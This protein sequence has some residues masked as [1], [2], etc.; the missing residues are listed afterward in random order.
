MSQ[1]GV[2]RTIGKL[3]TDERFRSQFFAN[4]QVAAH[5]AGLPLS[6]TELEALAALSVDAVVRF[7]QGVDPRITRLCPQKDADGHRDR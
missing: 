1:Q 6:V 3:C 7:G 2:E 4:P 5:E